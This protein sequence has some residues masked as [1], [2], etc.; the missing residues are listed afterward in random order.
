GDCTGVF[1]CRPRNASRRPTLP[2]T[3]AFKPENLVRH[4]DDVPVPPS[5]EKLPGQERGV[6][7]A[8]AI[9]YTLSSRGAVQ[10]EDGSFWIEFRNSGEQGAVFQ[11][12]SGDD[13]Y[14]PRTYTVEPHKHLQD[15][16]A[17]GTN[18]RAQY[19]LSV[20]GPN[21]FF[22]S[23]KGTLGSR[24]GANLDIRETYDEE[25]NAISLSITNNG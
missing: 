12:R 7:P 10:Q 20:Y 16:W 3:D 6:R 11:V 17:F 15:R 2:D 18:R 8:R 23:F 25:Q 9:P 21:G 22:R 19:D 4:P 5:H 1:D 24:H 14:P 13:V